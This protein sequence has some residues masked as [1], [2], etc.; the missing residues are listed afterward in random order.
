MPTSR[1]KP[2]SGFAA[3]DAEESEK[4]LNISLEETPSED[5]E[6]EKFLDSIVSETLEEIREMPSIV[7]TEDV[8][9]RFIQVEES[10]P[11]A[12]NVVPPTLVTPRPR[13]R[14]IPKFSRLK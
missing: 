4:V 14:N 7:P 9:P 5:E 2:S 12:K 13:P 10:T 3:T 6:V 11:A 1:K 8:G